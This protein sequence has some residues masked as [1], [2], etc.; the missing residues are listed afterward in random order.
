VAGGT[1]VAIVVVLFFVFL[2]MAALVSVVQEMV[3]QLIGARSTALRKA[4]RRMLQDDTY[5]DR[6]VNRFYRH[7]RVAA[8]GHKVR[9]LTCIDPND[10]AIAMATAIQP[11]N[12]GDD[13]I[14][15][16]PDSILALQ[17]GK[18]KQRL[19]LA[20]PDVFRTERD[21]EKIKEAVA[22]WYNAQMINVGQQFVTATRFRLYIVAAICTVLLN[23]SPFKI[24]EYLMARPEL[25][26]QFS[27]VV[28]ELAQRVS[29][30]GDTAMAA[31]TPPADADEPAGDDPVG[32][33]LTETKLTASDLRPLLVLYECKQG[34]NVLPIGWPWMAQLAAT[35]GTKARAIGLS[36]AADGSARSQ[37][38][39]C[40][41]ALAS[42]DLSPEAVTR[43][44]AL[45]IAAPPPV[46]KPAA[47][48]RPAPTAA[49]D[50]AAAPAA[51][52]AD[53]QPAP[54][55]AEA[56]PPARD[57]AQVAKLTAAY[58]TQF[59]PVYGPDPTRDPWLYVFGGWLITTAAAAQ[60]APFWFN[61]LKKLVARRP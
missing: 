6:I 3:A 13:A 49:P 14:S 24:V 57:E 2:T 18:L 15:A 35:A 19:R 55:I 21:P 45:G 48:T 46:A 37:A 22:S 7:P 41:R 54:E 28:P 17:D 51:P 12:S 8:P 5:D 34:V 10:F 47:T 53:A 38:E 39:A 40:G 29:S 56:A 61:L 30:A 27:L 32:V 16:L 33:A 20:L 58:A 11:N 25:A 36:G 59:T 4:V 31:F 26:H 42:A 9:N 44:T 23:V 60:G 1:L 50:P 43:L 52:P